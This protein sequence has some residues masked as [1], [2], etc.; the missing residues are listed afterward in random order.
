MREDKLNVAK[1][2]VRLHKEIEPNLER[3]FLLT[4]AE[5]DLEHEP[6]KL[7]EVVE[8]A[9]EAGVMPIYVR[10]DAKNGIPFASVIVELSPAEY[11]TFC[12]TP[13][14]PGENWSVG[15]ELALQ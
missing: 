3:A 9:V 5:D 4:S 13:V 14:I 11:E 8:G 2:L 1:N 10:P 7:L 12:N 15:Q 6:I